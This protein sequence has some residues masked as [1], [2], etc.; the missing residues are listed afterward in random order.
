MTH[1]GL[2]Q[3]PDDDSPWWARVHHE[4]EALVSAH[5]PPGATV[6]E[7]TLD[8][9]RLEVVLEYDLPQ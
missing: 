5:T 2:D 8:P 6:A 4:M 1:F 9:D 7:M 3:V